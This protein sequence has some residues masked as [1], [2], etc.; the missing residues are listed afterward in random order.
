MSTERARAKGEK[1]S[2]AE[3]RTAPGA[4]TICRR[5]FCAA[6]SEKRMSI[7]SANYV[8]LQ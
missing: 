7:K 8:L 5:G 4:G 3:Y 1:A 2:R 6:R